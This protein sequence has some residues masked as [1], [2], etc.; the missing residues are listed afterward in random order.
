MSGDGPVEAGQTWRNRDCGTH[1][2]AKSAVQSRNWI[3][4]SAKETIYSTDGSL[5]LRRRDLT[6]SKRELD[7]SKASNALSTVRS[8]LRRIARSSLVQT[9]SVLFFAMF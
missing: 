7:V 3:S 9:I 4:L 1:R 6:A 8:A 5:S 2:R